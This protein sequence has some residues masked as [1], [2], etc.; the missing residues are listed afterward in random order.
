[1]KLHH[2]ICNLVVFMLLTVQTV[3]TQQ[4][5]L[6]E[7]QQY[8]ERL[9][10][11]TTNETKAA[12]VG[13]ILDNNS[14]PTESNSQAWAEAF[15]NVYES[16]YTLSILT[17]QEKQAYIKLIANFF[18][19][20][21]VKN[22]SLE[23]PEADMDVLDVFYKQL[24]P[25]L[26]TAIRVR[27]LPEIEKDLQNALQN[28]ERFK[29]MFDDLEEQKQDLLEQAK[30]SSSFSPVHEKLTKLQKEMDKVEKTGLQYAQKAAIQMARASIL[31]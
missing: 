23:H 22:I 11:K 10:Q 5:S 1:M 3:H 19:K 28:V 14:L 12:I 7:Q 24:S 15:V 9:S 8:E 4:L 25:K 13:T 16:P 30:K 2:I 26:Q 21:D 27:L 17:P 6:A 20:I 29:N 31:R 18:K